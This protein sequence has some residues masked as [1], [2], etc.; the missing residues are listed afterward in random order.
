MQVFVPRAVMSDHADVGG[1]AFVAAAG[2]G[3]VGQANARRAHHTSKNSTTAV[4]RSRGISVGQY[5][6]TSRNWGRESKYPV[7]PCGPP[8]TSGTII[9]AKRSISDWS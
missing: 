8:V 3:D 6:K 7:V 5:P 9:R 2:V 1:R 4:T